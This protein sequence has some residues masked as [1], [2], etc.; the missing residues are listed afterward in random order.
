[1]RASGEIER[2]GLG[3]EKPV[4]VLLHKPKGVVCTNAKRE[5]KTRALDLVS[6]IK[7]RLFPVG[8]LDLDSEGLLLLTNDGSFAERM[9]HPRYGV[10]KTYKV[11][12]RGRIELDEVEKAKGGV[13]LA[14]G[15]TG[16]VRI[17][18]RRRTKERSYLEVTIREG[19]NR[20]IRRIFARFGYPVLRLT[21]TRIAGID[22]RGLKSGDSR[23]LSPS[24]VRE[25][26]DAASPETEDP[27]HA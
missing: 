1:M 23:F 17:R 19:R 8:R 12:L 21:R 20:E 9:M 14:E 22:I 5:Q 4:Y 24:E 26:I 16:G 10:P 27:S 25:L 13:W 6:H 18:L 15:R 2:E 3:P 11:T 7:G